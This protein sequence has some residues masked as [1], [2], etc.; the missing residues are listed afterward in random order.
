MTSWHL[1]CDDGYNNLL[2]GF[3]DASFFQLHHILYISARP[4]FPKNHFITSCNLRSHDN[5]L[6]N[7]NTVEIIKSSFFN[8]VR[9]FSAPVA[10]L[11]PS[12]LP[13]YRIYPGEVALVWIGP[14]LPQALS[15]ALGIP[16]F[17]HKQAPFFHEI[18]SNLRNLYLLNAKDTLNEVAFM[19]NH[20][21]DEN[22]KGRRLISMSYLYSFPRTG[23]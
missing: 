6:L 22:E 10:K 14:C 8:L 16:L 12:A 1:L 9:L 11:L 19:L 18:I 17:S 23:K 21:R 15:L 5:L 20:K 2:N 4:F 3:S 13:G 7:P